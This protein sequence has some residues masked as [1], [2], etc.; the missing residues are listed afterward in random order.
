VYGKGHEKS[1]KRIIKREKGRK[2]GNKRK[3][4]RS[5]Y[6]KYV[7]N[8]CNKKVIPAPPETGVPV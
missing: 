1:R 5:T 2:K 3:C 4:G 7:L 8:M 6:N